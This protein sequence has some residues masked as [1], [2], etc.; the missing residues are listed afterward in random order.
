M[1]MKSFC[2]IEN[3]KWKIDNSKATHGLIS[4]IS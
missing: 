2:L 3:G 4:Q 1:S